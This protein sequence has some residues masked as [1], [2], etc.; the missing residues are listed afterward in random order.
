MNVLGDYL[1]TMDAQKLSHVEE[2]HLKAKGP[3]HYETGVNT[4][5]YEITTDGPVF[6]IAFTEV[7]NTVTM[8]SNVRVN[9]KR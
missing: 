5:L 1:I 3:T 2:F 6:L 4:G 7:A 9:Y 8:K